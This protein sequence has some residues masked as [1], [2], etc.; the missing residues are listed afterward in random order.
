MAGNIIS[1]DYFKDSEIEEIRISQPNSVHHRT[2][3]NSKI[4]PNLLEEIHR[5]KDTM[6]IVIFPIIVF[7]TK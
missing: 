2:F 4:L 1:K 3:G 7:E 6:V 5:V